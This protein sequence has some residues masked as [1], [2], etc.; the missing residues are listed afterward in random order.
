[1]VSVHI[2]RQTNQELLTKTQPMSTLQL[3]SHQH[4]LILALDLTK[5]VNLVVMEVL[6]LAVLLM[7]EATKVAMVDHQAVNKAVTEVNNKVVMVVNNKVVMVVNNKAVMVAVL[8]AVLKQV[9]EHMEVHNKA[10]M[11]VML[12][13]HQLVDTDN[14]SNKA[15]AAH[16]V[17]NLVTVAQ[18][19]VLNKAVMANNNQVMLANLLLQLQVDM[20]ANNKEAMVDN[21][22][23]VVVR[24]VD[25]L[26]SF[27]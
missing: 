26:L 17:L 3:K 20:E 14:N 11:V 27:K 9:A 2:S 15:M 18:V 4:K 22:N 16:L 7:V 12:V 13:Q 23:K 24:Q 10:A 25:Q 21:K 8:V 6:Q 5:E 1:M 19:L